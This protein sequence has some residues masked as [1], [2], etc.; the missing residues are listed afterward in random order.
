MLKSIAPLRAARAAAAERLPVEE[1]E[2]SFEKDLASLGLWDDF[3]ATVNQTE[4]VRMLK[5][6]GHHGDS[7]PGATVADDGGAASPKGSG[8]PC[9]AWRPLHRALLQQIEES[10]SDDGLDSDLDAFERMATELER[11]V[12]AAE[13]LLF[14]FPVP[15]AIDA[16]KIDPIEDLSERAHTCPG[17]FRGKASTPSSDSS[18][19]SRRPSRGHA[20]PPVAVPVATPSSDYSKTSRRPSRGHATPPATPGTAERRPSKPSRHSARLAMPKQNARRSVA[21]ASASIV[22]S[23]PAS[24]RGTPRQSGRA[25][26]AKPSFSQPR[27]RASLV[28]NSP[29]SSRGAPRQ[30]GRASTARASFL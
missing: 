12:A 11:E 15:D 3:R 20:T 16:M 22:D 29:A 4:C 25:S 10:G 8:L 13:Q 27:A 18:K 23:S 26:T 28:D 19:I 30:A 9:G 17:G 1:V 14:P 5:E 2:A 21:V 24:R 6:A 7:H